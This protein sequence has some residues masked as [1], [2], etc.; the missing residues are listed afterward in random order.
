MQF[1]K[2]LLVMVLLLVSLFL[3]GGML[4]SAEQSAQQE[5]DLEKGVVA[6]WGFDEGE[7][8]IIF[9]DSK[10]N[11]DCLPKCAGE[12]C[13]PPKWV[14]GKIG[15]AMEFD[16]VDDYVDCGNGVSLDITDAITVAAWVKWNDLTEPQMILSKVTWDTKGYWLIKR[17]GAVNFY[18]G[19]GTGHVI[20]YK[21]AAE[22]VVG[23][24]YHIVGIYSPSEGSIKIYINTVKGTDASYF[25][26]ITT[27]TNR[28]TIGSRYDGWAPFNGTIDEVYIYNRALKESEIKALYKRNIGAKAV[29]G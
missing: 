3:I 12:G 2:V 5:I 11:N 16:G 28:L 7:G 20:A 26:S 15:S 23:Q 19:S 21:S 4:V 8:D 6:H 29:A 10:N 9:D 14:E 24:W 1:N 13:S 22:L 18:I 27:S 25:G 17:Y